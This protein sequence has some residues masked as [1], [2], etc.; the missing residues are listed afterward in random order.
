MR[1]TAGTESALDKIS[2]EQAILSWR[3]FESRQAYQVATS[4]VAPRLAPKLR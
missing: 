2:D 4:A 1:S 3:Q